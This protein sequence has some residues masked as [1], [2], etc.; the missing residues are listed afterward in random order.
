VHSH[1]HANIA[2]HTVI[3]THSQIDV[4]TK[5]R[6]YHTYTHTR[7]CAVMARSVVEKE[8]MLRWL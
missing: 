1:I 3:Y 5:R 7:E 8:P 2:A 6:L 4:Q